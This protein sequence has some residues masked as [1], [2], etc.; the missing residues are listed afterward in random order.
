MN[1]RAALPS[2]EISV[3]VPLYNEREN[4]RILHGEIVRVLAETGRTFEVL[5]VDDGS[6]DGSRLVLQGLRGEDDRVRV[7]KLRR[8]F[9]QT[10]ALA[11]GFDLAKGEIFVALDADLQN[12]PADIPRLL[13]RIHAG[14]DVVSGWRRRR[15]DPFLTRRLPSAIANGILRL[16]TGVPVHDT[17]CTL[18]A[19]R[20][21]VMR[22]LPLYAEMHRYLPVLSTLADA[23]IEE[24]EVAHRPRR[25]GRSKYGIARTFRFGLDLLTVK[26]LVQFAARPLHAFGL[27]TAPLFFLSAAFLLLGS[28]E[29]GR[30][31]YSRTVVY[32]ASAV[33]FFLAAIHLLLLGLLAEL[34][35]KAGTREGVGKWL[36][37]REGRR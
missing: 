36:P 2:P 13:D 6:T 24:I 35:V 27:A 10:A 12:D 29:G 31:Q 11:A 7:V 32:P 25:F 23:R 19:Y 22:R 28:V 9:G 17:G 5:Y 15:R 37:S 20:A 33:L 30:I 16:L 8:N 4:L 34:A 1:G 18:K 3:V 26:L 21:G 14:A